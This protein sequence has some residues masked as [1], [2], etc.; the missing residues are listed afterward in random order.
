MQLK[1]GL[2][3]TA[4]VAALCKE[5]LMGR[6][7]PW[8]L[9]PGAMLLLAVAASAWSAD[10]SPAGAL[11]KIRIAADGRRFETSEGKPF[12]P[13]GVNYYRPN[14]GWPPKLWQTFDP[15]VTRKDFALL[16]EYGVNCV[17]VYPTFGSMYSEKGVLTPEG[18]A[19]FDQFLDIAETHGI[20]VHPSGPDHWEGQPRWNNS[21][22]FGEESLQ[23][24][25]AF[26]KLFAARYKGRNV[27]FAYDLRNEPMVPWNSPSM[28]I[29]WNKWVKDRYGT[30][31]AAAKAWGVPSVDLAKVAIPKAEDK[32]GDRMLPD[33]QNCRED[34]AD[35]WARRQVEA[36][37][38]VDPN[39][40][41]TV[42]NIQWS[43][44]A[45]VSR[46][47]MYGAF[48]PERQ[49]KYLDFL[50]FHFYPL[51]KGGYE[52][53]DPVMEQR[54]LAYLEGI[55][56]EVAKVGKPVVIG[57]FG[58]YGGGT[59][60][61]G[62]GQDTKFATETQQ[63]DFLAKMVRVTDGLVCGWLNWGIYD[64]PEARDCSR[65]TGLFTVDG[66]P[67]AWA[68][69]FRE[70]AGYYGGRK[71]EARVMGNRPDLPWGLCIT[72]SQASHRFRDEYF[73]AFQAEQRN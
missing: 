5:T 52:Y 50:S 22:Q 15:E 23:A 11:P 65:C 13:F 36:I 35:E 54:N 30:A 69:R 57:E 49:A 68:L 33:Y 29:R 47:S 4:M 34:A 58:W 45:N 53:D 8:V 39:A 46:V 26:W 60:P 43:I 56:R 24:I 38:S 42:G 61:K 12:V 25:E 51:D 44:P 28:Q 37:K 9:G 6:F 72:D 71:I 32:P 48:R 55:A 67:K 41:V 1:R 21:D 64:H 62:R 18:I 20:Y 3:V 70:L 73:K 66:K 2:A 14:T 63:A 27:I 16:K 59:F 7:A 19:K 17:R 31:D 10:L 40:L